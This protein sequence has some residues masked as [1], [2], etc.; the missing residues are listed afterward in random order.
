MGSTEFGERTRRFMEKVHMIVAW[1]VVFCMLNGTIYNV[2]RTLGRTLFLIDS[3][4]C[5]VRALSSILGG[6]ICEYVNMYRVAWNLLMFKERLASEISSKF[7][8]MSKR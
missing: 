5:G 6:M 2:S 3:D 7:L 4:C 1:F 8:S